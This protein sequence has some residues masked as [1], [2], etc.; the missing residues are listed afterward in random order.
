MLS[1]SV[2]S[3]PFLFG[4]MGIFF[5]IMG[6]NLGSF[7]SAV[8]YRA[9]RGESWIFNRNRRGA[10][11]SECPQ[12]GH[13]L[14]VLDLIPL[15]SWLFLRGRCRYCH[16]AIGRIYPMLE[17]VSG[18]VLALYFLI[19]GLFVVEEGYVL[20]GTLV[21]SIFLPFVVAA[22]SALILPQMREGRPYPRS[23]VLMGLLSFAGM[24]LLTGCLI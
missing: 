13:R 18:S 8:F 5:F 7:A 15:F 17:L 1:L 10:A 23:L 2:S 22:G 12:C 20:F 21:F 19:L 4:M 3:D 14:G 9:C 11:R 24:V 16:A 6:L